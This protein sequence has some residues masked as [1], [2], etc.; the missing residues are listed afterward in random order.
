MSLKAFHLFFLTIA[1][2][3]S[4]FFG[5]WAVRDWRANGDVTVLLLGLASFAVLVALVP[6]GIWFLRKFKNA[7]YL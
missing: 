6:Y 4:L 1:G 2:F 5:L 7:G 3:S